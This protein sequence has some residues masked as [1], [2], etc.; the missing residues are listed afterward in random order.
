MYH[1]LA[2]RA[3]S[4]RPATRRGLLLL[5]AV[6]VVHGKPAEE[7]RP[8][9]AELLRRGPIPWAPLHA[10]GG[11]HLRFASYTPNRLELE[12]FQRITRANPRNCTAWEKGGSLWQALA[13]LP[14]S[15]GPVGEHLRSR[16]HFI[17]PAT[18]ERVSSEI[19]PLVGSLRH[20]TLGVRANTSTRAALMSKEHYI[21]PDRTLLRR[22]LGVG[23][24]LLFYDVGA[25]LFS[26]GAGGDGGASQEWFA[27]KYG[28]RAGRPY[29]GF[30]M[31]WA[32]EAIPYAPDKLW[33]TFP[34]EVIPRIHYYNVPAQTDPSS[35]MNP[36]YTLKATARPGDFVVVKLDVDHQPTELALVR[37]LLAD[38]ELAGLIDDFFWEHHVAGSIVGCPKIWRG[39]PKGGWARMVFDSTLGALET[40][41]ES[42]AIFMQ[43]RCRGIRAHSWV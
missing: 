35:P 5:A 18:R 36:W 13:G 15:T 28:K 31:I 14:S 43:L 20:H 11:S 4:P 25:S 33:S 6:L 39:G 2:S 34:P 40:L 32:W 16:M 10:Q 26:S 19:E 17:D 27:R 21:L 22:A 12:W 7:L 23:G 42:Y 1:P 8:M 24:R 41:A 9:C 38:P 3:V 37:Q 29:P 30:D